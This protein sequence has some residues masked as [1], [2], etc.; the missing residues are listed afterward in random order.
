MRGVSECSGGLGHELGACI[1]NLLTQTQVTLARSR[2]AEDYRDVLASNVEEFE[3]LSRMIADMLFIAKD[4]RIRTIRENAVPLSEAIVDSG[5][6]IDYVLELNGGTARRL[7]IRAGHRV[8]NELI[9][10]LRKAR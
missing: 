4:G 5:G 10:S 6:P 1:G 3:R 7:G 2:A 9:D 8:R